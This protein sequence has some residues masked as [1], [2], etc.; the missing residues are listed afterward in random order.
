MDESILSYFYL[1]FLLDPRY[2]K[3]FSENS[4]VGMINRNLEQYFDQALINKGYSPLTRSSFTYDNKNYRD[5]KS[6]I[7]SKVA[8]VLHKN[9]DVFLIEN[10]PLFGTRCKVNSD[11][12]VEICSELESHISITKNVSLKEDIESWGLSRFK[13]ILPKLY[14]SINGKYDDSTWVDFYNYGNLIDNEAVNLPLSDKIVEVDRN[15]Q[16]VVEIVD[17]S[18]QLVKQLQTANDLGDLTSDEASAAVTEVKQIIVAFE[19]SKIRANA[20][21]ESAKKSLSWIA[22]KGADAAIGLLATSLLV[23]IAAYFGLSI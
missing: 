13:A 23:A 5:Y 21:F 8:S 1:E 10:H 7:V 22:A 4:N 11:K 2:P 16:P 9:G 20:V 17:L 15:S 19:S 3:T 18:E 12:F 14:D 6:S